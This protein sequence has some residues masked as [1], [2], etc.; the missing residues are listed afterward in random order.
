M[1]T[2]VES[3]VIS[4]RPETLGHLRSVEA[5]LHAVSHLTGGITWSETDSDLQITVTLAE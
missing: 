2:P 3:M 1:K 5:D 4:G